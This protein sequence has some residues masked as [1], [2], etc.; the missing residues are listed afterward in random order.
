MAESPADALSQ[1]YADS[2]DQESML[3]DFSLLQLKMGAGAHGGS[4]TSTG[5]SRTAGTTAPPEDQE[6]G[7]RGILNKFD[8]CADACV[9]G[10]PG[11]EPEYG[12]IEEEAAV[13]SNAT[14]VAKSARGLL[15]R[16]AEHRHRGGDMRRRWVDTVSRRRHDND[17]DFERCIKNCKLVGVDIDGIFNSAWYGDATDKESDSAVPSSMISDAVFGRHSDTADKHDPAVPA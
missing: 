14:Q 9:Q 4:S 11:P 10:Y 8:R 5:D 12:L 13:I 16:R 2:D 7:G 6:E 1:R 17:Y 15:S 3:M